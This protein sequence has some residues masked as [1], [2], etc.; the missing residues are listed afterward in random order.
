MLLASSMVIT[1]SLPTRSIACAMIVPI[2]SSLFAEMVP[3]CAIAWP[4]TGLDCFFSALMTTSTARSMPRFSA[5]GL[6]RLL[7]INDLPAHR[8]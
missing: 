2:V 6:P 3:T 7:S 8:A 1:P 5:I 4:L